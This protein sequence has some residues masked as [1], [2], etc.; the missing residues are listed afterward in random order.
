MIL[1]IA[2]SKYHLSYKKMALIG[3]ICGGIFALNTS[4]RIW[5]L[6]IHDPEKEYRYIIV[7]I[8][9]MCILPYLINRFKKL[10]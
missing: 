5:S 1:I 6:Y 3:C 7:V 4:R 9:V 8:I 10:L 2:K